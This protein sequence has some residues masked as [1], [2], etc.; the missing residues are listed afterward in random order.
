MDQTATSSPGQGAQGIVGKAGPK[1]DKGDPGQKG[2]KGDQGITIQ[3]EVAY[4]FMS[5]TW[6]ATHAEFLETPTK[7]TD[8][9]VFGTGTI[10]NHQ[11]FKV[12]LALA[13]RMSKGNTYI[14]NVKFWTVP[15]TSDCDIYLAVCDSNI[16]YG[17]LTLDQGGVHSAKWPSSSTTCSYFG[18]HVG[19]SKQQLW[20]F[21]FELSPSHTIAMSWSGS[22]NVGHHETYGPMAASSGLWL[23]VGREEPDES[24]E[25]RFIEVSIKT[26]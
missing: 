26:T 12:R 1:G 14:I 18:P 9:L 21:R 6:L 4:Y 15:L 19:W 25:I 3:K 17:F 13:G 20:D 8:R 5:P 22:A 10:N 23:V 2:E 11:L 24:Q 16:C 7:H